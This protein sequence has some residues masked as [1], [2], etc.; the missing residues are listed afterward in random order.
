MKEELPNDEFQHVDGTIREDVIVIGPLGG[1]WPSGKLEG[2]I[3][4]MRGK[5]S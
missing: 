3:E 2:G 1:G 5:R 4:T